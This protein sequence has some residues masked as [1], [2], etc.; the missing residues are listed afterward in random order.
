MSGAQTISVSSDLSDARIRANRDNS[1]KSTGPRSA[2]GKAKSSMNR[3]SHGFFSRKVVLE[4]EDPQEFELLRCELI[5]EHRPSSLTQRFL[6]ERIAIAMW[7]LNRMQA[8]E[9]QTH[10]W[11]RHSIQKACSQRIFE[12]H[13]D[14][15]ST[16][17]RLLDG[18][19]GA[20]V[21]EKL[22][23]YERRLEGTI[24]RCLRQLSRMKQEDQSDGT[25]PTEEPAEEQ[26][27][28]TPT[29]LQG[30]LEQAVECK[31]EVREGSSEPIGCIGPSPSPGPSPA[32]RGEQ[33]A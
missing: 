21:L 1:Q 29:S 12:Q 17:L 9:E 22:E 18:S 15:A 10:H 4:G 7:R 23:L 24:H 14:V 2:E 30:E 20:S 31:K 19:S 11:E 32:G 33:S 27:Q 13:R 8:I 3:C 28:P 6:V 25:N 16:S 5:A 26:Q